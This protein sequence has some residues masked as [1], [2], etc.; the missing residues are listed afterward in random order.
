MNL[1]GFCS[2]QLILYS[3][4]CFFF[5]LL[6]W[7]VF[8]R[9]T[10]LNGNVIS[11]SFSHKT[12]QSKEFA[13]ELQTNCKNVVIDEPKPNYIA[14]F[15]CF[16]VRSH[17]LPFLRWNR[18]RRIHRVHKHIAHPFFRID[19]INSIRYR[20]EKQD[21]L[22]VLISVYF[23]C[24]IRILIEYFVMVSPWCV[25]S[26]IKRNFFS[27]VQY[28]LRVFKN[29]GVF[30]R[31]FQYD[32]VH[33]R[34]VISSSWSSSAMNYIHKAVCCTR[35]WTTNRISH[36]FN[37]RKINNIIFAHKFGN[38]PFVISI[39][40][41]KKTEM[42]GGEKSSSLLLYH[43]D[44]NW[45]E[46]PIRNPQPFFGALHSTQQ[47]LHLRCICKLIDETRKRKF[48]KWLIP[49]SL[50]LVFCCIR[51]RVLCAIFYVNVNLKFKHFRFPVDPAEDFLII[52]CRLNDTRFEKDT[53]KISLEDES[54]AQCD[55]W[56]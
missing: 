33:F 5:H 56:R 38:N 36:I 21:S 15:Q 31:C 47:M 55:Q 2:F 18:L 44:L 49:I 6:S 9:K 42:M 19:C 12:S 53:P 16:F 17:H 28:F 54:I 48:V 23:K 14:N 27:H 10:S 45:I 32:F 26:N 43:F 4:G 50:A 37:T 22:C 7:I 35:L 20:R 8:Q 30:D 51:M 25:D 40:S 52:S 39:H 11:R 46:R 13:H 41:T 1:F 34:F 3:G 24:F 29:L